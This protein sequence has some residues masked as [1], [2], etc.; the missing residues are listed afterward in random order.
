M[1]CIYYDVFKLIFN[2]FIYILFITYELVNYIFIIM[3]VF[4][5]I[6]N[7]LVLMNCIY[8]NNVLITY[9]FI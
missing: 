6:E 1:N 4:K 2:Q 8:Y 9:F 3:Y 7:E 5:F